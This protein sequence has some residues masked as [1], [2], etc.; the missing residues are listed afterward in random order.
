[1]KEELYN[2][3]RNIVIQENDVLKTQITS[4]QTQ[5]EAVSRQCN[6]IQNDVAGVSRQCN[7]IQTRITNVNNELNTYLRDWEKYRGTYYSNHNKIVLDIDA[8]A[9][10]VTGTILKRT[11]TVNKNT[12]IRTSDTTNNVNK[13]IDEKLKQQMDFLTDS[14]EG[15]P[16]ILIGEIC[17]NIVGESYSKW[18]SISMYYPTIVFVFNERTENNRPRR[19]QIK[20]RFNKL[21]EEL[22]TQDLEQLIYRIKAQPSIQYVYG[23][24]RGNYVSQD[25]RFKT[26]V[27]GKDNVVIS[28]LLKSLFAVIPEPYDQKLLFIT[29]IGKKRPSITKRKKNLFYLGLNTVDY[30]KEFV[31]ELKSVN[32]LVNGISKVIKLV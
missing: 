31:M 3:I 12:T 2:K 19:S 5:L 16:Y 28:N 26:T 10:E 21:T 7:G 11:N 1:M 6:G 18:D 14:K 4:L 9:A 8:A 30:D 17:S 22:T 13:H 24:V 23:T 25:K 20:L 29:N 32:I 27:F 15:F